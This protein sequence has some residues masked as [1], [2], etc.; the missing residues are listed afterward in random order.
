MHP[1]LKHFK[2]TKSKAEM[3]TKWTHQVLPKLHIK[4]SIVVL[5]LKIKTETF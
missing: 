3:K 5:Q 4:P 1:T 2:H